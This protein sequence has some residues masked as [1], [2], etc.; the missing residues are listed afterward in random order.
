MGKWM[1][2]CPFFVTTNYLLIN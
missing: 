1:T 2:I